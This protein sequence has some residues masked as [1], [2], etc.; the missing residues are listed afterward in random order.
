MTT[1]RDLRFEH[2]AFIVCCA[3][4]ACDSPTKPITG[5]LGEVPIEISSSRQVAMGL[6]FGWSPACGISTLTVSTV[7]AP[8]ASAV[9]VWSLTAP[10]QT[11]VGPSITYGVP[12]R[13]ASAPHAA[14]PL[15]HGLTYRVSIAYV[16]GGD[17]IAGSGQEIFTY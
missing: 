5:C 12:P 13:G 6:R 15:I 8:G 4:I 1:M 9:Q 17:G 3:T 7:P 11:P 16:V 2:V 10:E 14:V